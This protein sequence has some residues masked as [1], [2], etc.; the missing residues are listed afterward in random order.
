MLFPYSSVWLPNPKAFFDLFEQA[1]QIPAA[2][3]S[4]FFQKQKEKAVTQGASRRISLA[5]EAA[6]ALLQWAQEGESYDFP[7][8]DSSGRG[9]GGGTELPGAGGNAS[10]SDGE[11]EEE[12][13]NV[14]NITSTVENEEAPEWARSV[15]AATDDSMLPE[16]DESSITPILKNVELRPY[17][18]QAL[19]WMMQRE[20]PPSESSQE[21]LQKQLDLLVELTTT[22]SSSKMTTDI[23]RPQN[24]DVH[25][26]CGP[27]IVS[28]RAAACSL[29]I[30][31]NLDDGA[32]T[33]THPLWERR[34]LASYDRSRTMSFYVQPLFL[35]ATAVAPE[36]PSPCRGG[37]LADSMYVYLLFAVS[38]ASFSNI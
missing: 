26:E 1:R 4:Q 9:V 37:I 21:D 36:P 27:V 6:F 31:G 15:T 2:A 24:V 32:E 3:A 14:D 10:G 11:A 29:S 28:K 17:Q 34:Y 25:C 7:T 5:H 33:A 16:F 19:R 35:T 22:S 23:H 13:D 38:F 8:A 12:E 30:V 20:L 18:R